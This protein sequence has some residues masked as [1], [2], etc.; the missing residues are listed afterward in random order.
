[1]PAPGAPSPS[2]TSK[3]TETTSIASS[4]TTGHNEPLGYIPSQSYQ[5]SAGS[6]P[7]E[8]EGDSDFEAER[9]PP[10]WRPKM[11]QDELARLKP[12][13]KKRQDVING[14]TN[15][16][17]I[18]HM[19]MISKTEYAKL[20]IVYIWYIFISELFHTERTH[21]R[22]LKVLNH[23]FYRPLQKNELMPKELFNRLF[24]NLPEV[25][26]LH[27]EYNQIMKDRV[28]SSGFPIGNISDILND[29][30]SR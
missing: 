18:F 3:N 8:I 4:S 12:K 6:G 14:K 22:K 24:A 30:V 27:V 10:D 26:A 5:S 15:K 17:F 1:M 28:K 20:D 29:M 11:S 23:F 7:R 9:D 19:H 16:R 13:E 21:V 25:L 2:I